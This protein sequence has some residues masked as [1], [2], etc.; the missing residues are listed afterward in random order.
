VGGV[1][2]DVSALTLIKIT[3]AG[4]NKKKF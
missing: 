3:L 4:E 2:I 1:A